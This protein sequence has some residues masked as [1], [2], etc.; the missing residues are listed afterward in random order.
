MWQSPPPPPKGRA[1]EGG[2]GL[3]RRFKG[4]C[5]SGQ[6]RLGK[7][8]GRVQSGWG[9]CK[10]VGENSVALGCPLPRQLRWRACRLWTAAGMHQKGKG[11][12]RRPQKRLDRR[13]SGW[14]RLLSVTNAL[15]GG[16]RQSAGLTVTPKEEDGCAPPPPS[17]K[18]HGFAVRIS[19]THGHH[20][21]LP[22][23]FAVAVER[24]QSSGSWGGGGQCCTGYVY[25][26]CDLRLRLA[27]LHQGPLPFQAHPCPR[28]QGRTGKG[29]ATPPPPPSRAP[30]LSPATI[31]PNG[32][33]RLQWHL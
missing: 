31:P 3:M 2:G 27:H 33:C 30:G 6:R 10:A 22:L 19:H 21:S 26:R 7:R 9:G 24:V 15:R 16:E 29:G 13:R 32:K 28:G 4:G 25:R 20:P 5:T 23:L 12:Q 17:L 11:P 1:L 8:L 18:T 14:G